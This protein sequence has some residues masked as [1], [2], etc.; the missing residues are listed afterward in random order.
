MKNRWHYNSKRCFGVAFAAA[1]FWVAAAYLE[2]FQ[3]IAGANIA[4]ICTLCCSLWVGVD[5]A[6]AR[7]DPQKYDR[8]YVR[9]GCFAAGMA[10]GGVL[11][12]LVV[13]A[14]ERALSV[15]TVMVPIS[16]VLICA[17]VWLGWEYSEKE[18]DEEEE[19][20][21]KRRNKRIFLVEV[22]FLCLFIFVFFSGCTAVHGENGD[23][24]IPGEHVICAEKTGE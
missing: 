2:R 9:G 21:R 5:V 15:P 12:A 13:F 7:Y 3:L 16:N 19:R 24:V 1:V 22:L 18:N 6:Y 8:R 10:L 20:A 14:L 17:S 11:A 4:S 23:E